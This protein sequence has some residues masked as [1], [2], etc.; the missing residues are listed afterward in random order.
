MPRHTV[1]ASIFVTFALSAC[2]APGAH[3]MKK[4]AAGQIGTGDRERAFSRALQVVQRDGWMVA[5]SDR[6]AGLLTTQSMST[7]AKPCG[8]MTC[9]S[10][11]TLQITIA[12]SGDVVVNLHRE[13]FPPGGTAWFVPTLERDVRVIEAEQDAVLAAIVG[14]PVRAASATATASAH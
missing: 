10:R 3:V 4:T 14:T 13:F 5:V 7:G 2:V 12:E 6:A 8:I 1:L 9:D 11:S